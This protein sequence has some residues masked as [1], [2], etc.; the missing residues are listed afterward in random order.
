MNTYQSVPDPVAPDWLTA[1]L[2]QSGAMP[3]GHVIAAEN[4]MTNAF[5][6]Q[7][8]R[9]R[10]KYS[11]DAPERLPTQLVLKRNT[12]AA[13]SKEAGAEEVKFYELIASQAGRPPIYIPCLAAEYDEVSGNSY[14]LLQ[15]ISETH[16]PPITRDQQLTIVEGVPS[17]AQI[18]SVVDALAQHH[19]FWWEHKLLGTNTFHVGYWWRNAERF[20]LY[21][22]RRKTSWANLMA[23]AGEWLPG[24]IR[25][26]YEQVMLKLPQYWQQYLEPRFKA[27]SNLTLIHGDAYFSNFLSP[28]Q[29]DTAGANTYMLDWQS[30]SFDIG[31]CDLANLCA[32][33]WTPAQRYDGQRE[34]RI[35]KHYLAQIQAHGV[36]NYTWQDLLL[37]YR[38][39][40]MAWLLVP[41]Q[42]GSDGAGKDYWWPKMQCLVQAFQDW[43]CEALLQ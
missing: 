39:S 13:W 34:E 17:P 1:V 26:L 41:V 3:H 35:L 24:D 6:S 12:Q 27:G 36:A 40:I 22:A 20:N 29:L 31:A 7:T 23:Q 42:D 2:R 11:A 38:H 19:A 43:H 16:A 33:F 9:L 14:I 5:N 32:T 21:L 18:T 37:D 28:R 25:E 8:S 4:N 15:D 30:P 10:L